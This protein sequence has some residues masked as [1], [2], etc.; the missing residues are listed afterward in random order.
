M[1]LRPESL[2]VLSR[3]AGPSLV[4]RGEE[5]V[6]TPLERAQELARVLSGAQ[7]VPLPGAGHLPNQEVPQAFNSAVLAFLARISG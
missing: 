6:I 3:F 5:D 4:I 1:A 7:F 2:D